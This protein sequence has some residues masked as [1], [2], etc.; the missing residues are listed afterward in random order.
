MARPGFDPRARTNPKNNNAMEK[1]T[2]EQRVAMTILE[3]PIGEITIDG[4]TYQIPAPT[5]GTLM[6][7][8]GLVSRLP[9]FDITV[10]DAELA[11]EVLSHAEGA[12]TLARIAATLMLGAKRIAEQRTV[13]IPLPNKKCWWW[14][15]KTKPRFRAENEL[16][17]LTKRILENFT[18]GQLRELTFEV[19][20]EAGLDDFFALT[21]SLSTKSLLTPTR[22]VGETTARGASSSDGQSTS[23]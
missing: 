15:W 23:K 18:A 21:T 10:S 3:E 11:A 4:K 8:S 20:H 12:A 7:V 9:Q 5:T 22:E 16:D 6:A 2:I 14:P 17:Y 13:K 1:P 19:V